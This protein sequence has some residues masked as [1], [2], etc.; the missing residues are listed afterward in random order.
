MSPSK[1]HQG[2]AHP[3][4]ARAFSNCPACRLPS[5]AFTIKPPTLGVPLLRPAAA[6]VLFCS[7]RQPPEGTPEETNWTVAGPEH[8]TWPPSVEHSP[9]EPSSFR[10]GLGGD[11]SWFRGTKWVWA[12]IIWAKTNAQK[13]GTMLL[14]RPTNLASLSLCEPRS[15][16]QASFSEASCSGFEYQEIHLINRHRSLLGK[17][18]SSFSRFL[19]KNTVGEKP[20]TPTYLQATLHWTPLLPANTFMIQKWSTRKPDFFYQPSFSEKK[21]KQGTAAE[22]RIRILNMNFVWQG[23]F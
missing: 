5:A 4:N 17:Q 21:S 10:P 18:K 7:K 22:W 15:V 9:P 6:P 13:L 12:Q 19:A 11:A 8:H 16:I 2:H 3:P 1:V 20:T 14:C 23:M